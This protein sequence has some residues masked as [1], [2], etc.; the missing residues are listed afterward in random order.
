MA[1]DANRNRI[2]NNTDIEKPMHGTLDS[3]GPGK[4]LSKTMFFSP[5]NPSSI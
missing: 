4:N 2:F 5:S 3:P 1:A